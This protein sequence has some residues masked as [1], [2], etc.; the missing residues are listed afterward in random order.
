MSKVIV[1]FNALGPQLSK[2]DFKIFRDGSMH[3]I[4]RD[5][6]I[7]NFEWFFKLPID[8]ITDKMLKHLTE[9]PIV[10]IT[11]STPKLEE[12]IIG[13]LISARRLYCFQEYLAAIALCGIIGEM[14]AILIW[15][16]NKIDVTKYAKILSSCQMKALASKPFEE[17]DQSVRV[18]ILKSVG[19]VVKGSAMA[20]CFGLL[21]GFR[22]PY[23]HLL[24]T[25]HT[26]IRKD[27]QKSFGASLDLF[28]DVFKIKLINGR[29]IGMDPA[30]MKLFK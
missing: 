13:P 25:D 30:M 27:A 2:E 10:S 1:R 22:R 3:E 5:F 19:L 8:S 9:I 21:R 20:Q 16:V 11:L 29:S 23:M 14:L 24:T 26:R 28:Q 12:R 17:F 15:D 18:E 6:L 7:Q 4:N